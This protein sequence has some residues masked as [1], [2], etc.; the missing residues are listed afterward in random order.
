MNFLDNLGEVFSWID[1]KLG[2]HL[3]LVEILVESI[4]VSHSN[5]NAW[6]TY[7]FIISY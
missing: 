2:S 3:V 1:I 5:L 4:L 7:D 6:I